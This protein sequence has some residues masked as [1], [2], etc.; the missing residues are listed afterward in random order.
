M[1]TQQLI[2]ELLPVL[3]TAAAAVAGLKSKRLKKVLLSFLTEDDGLNQKIAAAVSVS[4]SALQAA[5][6]SRA[7][8]LSRMEAELADL[9][10]AVSSL[11][12]SDEK[13]TARIAE[14]EA[15]IEV[16]RKENDELR[17]ELARRRG[18][19]PKKSTSEQG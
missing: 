18:G 8:E 2:T 12:R 13:K 3:G 11:K 5:L 9:Q 15:E 6:D 1:N 7:E 17:A 4:I 10:K 16:L 14:L 19:R